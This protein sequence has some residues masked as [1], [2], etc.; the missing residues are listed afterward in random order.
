MCIRDR[1][2]AVDPVLANAHNGAAI[3]TP[4]GMVLDG[5]KDRIEAPPATS[6]LDDPDG[7]GV[8]NEIP[9]S[10]VDFMEFYLLNYFKPAT[11]EQTPAVI[12]GRQKFQAVSYTH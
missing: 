3:T 1:L 2:Q 11:Y 7:D 4:S 6:V 10:I 12:A 9:T 5:T 8:S